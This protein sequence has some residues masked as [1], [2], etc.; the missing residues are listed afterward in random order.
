MSALLLS[1]LVSGILRDIAEGRR[2]E[3]RLLD[4]NRVIAL[5]REI[6]SATLD[7][8]TTWS[9]FEWLSS[10]LAE[11]NQNTPI[12][13]GRL[14]SSR[15]GHLMLNLYYYLSLKRST[16]EI[17]VFILDRSVANSAFLDLVQMEHDR[18]FFLGPK[19]SFIFDA[20][21][22]GKLIDPL[23]ISWKEGLHPDDFSALGGQRPLFSPLLLESAVRD[24]F[25]HL[26]LT[27]KTSFVC[28][29]NR[30][31]AYL[32][33]I[34]GDGNFHGHRDFS[35][36]SYESAIDTLARS[37]VTP[38]RIGSVV[39]EGSS[40]IPY[41][42]DA[43]GSLSEEQYLIWLAAYAK[44]WVTGNS[45]VLLARTIFKKPVLVVNAFP[46]TFE[47][48]SSLPPDSVVLLRPILNSATG[49]E[50]SLSELFQYCTSYTIHNKHDVLVDHGLQMLD[51][52]E[53]EISDAVE[54]SL[55]DENV[56][57][58]FSGISGL[59]KLS[60]QDLFLVSNKLFAI[61]ERL[62]LTILVRGKASSRKAALL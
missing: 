28:F 56:R 44:L 7:H 39:A 50:L 41:L 22:Q 20:L 12:R 61:A 27:T 36:T 25:S 46:L 11:I 38:V 24:R 9:F 4:L 6:P 29:H 17:T 14:Y 60:S 58:E 31:S 51:N 19:H 37:G 30:D 55:A 40:G 59:A 48:L 47:V 53:I 16:K 35:F 3:E 8:T 1:D 33:K 5:Y 18:L 15:I 62:K 57:S 43:T 23:V 13:I 49:K 2:H 54:F 10:L 34:G 21:V 26:G 52:T 32:E 45:G 42:I